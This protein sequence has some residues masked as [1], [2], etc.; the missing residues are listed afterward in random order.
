MEPLESSLKI[1][2]QDGFIDLCV[3]VCVCLLFSSKAVV[4]TGHQHLGPG[5]GRFLVSKSK[6]ELSKSRKLTKGSLFSWVNLGGC[7]I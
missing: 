2:F 6:T 1:P 5:P 3:C 7:I 4:M